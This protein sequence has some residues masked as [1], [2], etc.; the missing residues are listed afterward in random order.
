M[1]RDEGFARGLAEIPPGQR[2]G[3]HFKRWHRRR[4]CG[5]HPTGALLGGRGAALA[6]APMV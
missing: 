3:H 4:G 1:M 5:R 2:Q 6:N